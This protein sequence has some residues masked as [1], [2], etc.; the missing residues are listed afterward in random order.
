MQKPPAA[1][2]GG[3]LYYR[4]LLR[5]ESCQALHPAN[6]QGP[7]IRTAGIGAAGHIDE[8]NKVPAQLDIAVIA[9]EQSFSGPVKE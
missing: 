5:I 4:L 7:V 3:G 9:V 8:A 6:C 2:A 1:S